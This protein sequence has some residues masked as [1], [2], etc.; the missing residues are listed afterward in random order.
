MT[1]HAPLRVLVCGTLLGVLTECDAPR[2]EAALFDNGETVRIRV[3][4]ETGN[5]CVIH[6]LMF[7]GTGEPDRAIRARLMTAECEGKP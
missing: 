2:R 5:P 7:G 3:I 6:M 4:R 1:A